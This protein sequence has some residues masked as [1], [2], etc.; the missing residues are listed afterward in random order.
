MKKTATLHLALILA[1]GSA[2]A[3]PPPPTSN[4]FYET[5]D[6]EA[7]MRGS[8][9]T[10]VEAAATRLSADLPSLE[11]RLQT[12]SPGILR[13]ARKA[14]SDSKAWRP[15]PPSADRLKN[16]CPAGAGIPDGAMD[17]AGISLW[18]KDH[19]QQ[20][21]GPDDVV[22]CLPEEYRRNYVVAHNSI[23]GQSSDVHGP[24]VLMFNSLPHSTA[25][26]GSPLKCVLS[27]N[28]GESTLN[29]A[30][31]LEFMCNDRSRA[32]VEF[33]DVD[34]S[35]GRPV[36][37]GGN[38]PACMGCHGTDGAA[39]PGGPHTIF[40]PEGAWIRFV[41][42][43]GACNDDEAALQLAIEGAAKAA[44]REN[45]RYRCLDLRPGN[46]NPFDVRGLP[47]TSTIE[48]F[49]LAVSELNERRLAQLTVTTPNYD[50]Y[51][52]AIAGHEFCFFTEANALEGWLP[53]S[54][55]AKHDSRASLLPVIADS[56]DLIGTV[57]ASLVRQESE[58]ASLRAGVRAATVAVRAG[59]APEFKIATNAMSCPFNSLSGAVDGLS[60]KLGQSPTVNRFLADSLLR[61][62]RGLEFNPILRFLLE[63]RGIDM[64][65]WSMDPTP[66]DYRRAPDRLLGHLLD[67]EPVG[68]ELKKLQP[69]MLA[70]NLGQ[71][72]YTVGAMTND[73]FSER[74]SKRK[75]LCAKLKALSMKAFA[76]DAKKG[77]GGLP[78]PTTT[79]Q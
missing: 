28:G 60:K 65:G 11:A 69:E 31:N 1:S 52:Y 37:N 36:V 45:P 12:D 33:T 53:D 73:T 78:V 10:R 23:A 66:G 9:R 15:P 46:G 49:D 43:G 20:L 54:V 13:I 30:S 64:S 40:D 44:M 74:D 25:D 5:A 41:R 29:N 34:F 63:G 3:G 75:K 67:L 7:A 38:P 2:I 51:K 70:L 68:S 57:R 27:I 50:R 32:Q 8:D 14:L 72:Q 19:S 79:A 17:A 24:R 42:G 77:E 62:F 58:N 26:G 71:K 22:C 6:L 61:G 56:T 35:T 39:G 4:A 21:K 18:I 59:R 48:N 76:A 16:Q 55:L 47:G